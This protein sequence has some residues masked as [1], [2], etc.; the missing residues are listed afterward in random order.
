MPTAASSSSSSSLCK[1]H[2]AA[3]RRRIRV[4]VVV[5]LAVLLLTLA[6]GALAITALR[7]HPAD[8]TISSIRLTSVSLSPGPGR[9]SLNVTLDAV[10]AI[11]NPSRVASFAHSPG[12]ALV[13]Y[14]GGVAAEAAVPPG[15]V[16]AGGSESVTVSVAVLADRLLLAPRL[17]DDVVGGGGRELPLAVQTTL[18]GTVTVLGLLRR[19]AVVF[20]ACKVTVSVRRPAEQS[21]STSSCRYRTKF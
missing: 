14:R 19:R 1:H 15:R 18:P 11:H 16:A 17:Y 8:T 9:L 7:P 20:T 4:C 10:L 6:V 5:S 12:H 3:S 21:S 13:Y 2:A